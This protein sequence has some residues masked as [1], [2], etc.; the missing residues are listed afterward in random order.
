MPKPAAVTRRHVLTTAIAAPLLARAAAPP[1]M[2]AWMR[3]NNPLERYMADFKRT[4]DAWEEG[5]VRGIAIGRMYFMQPGGANLPVFPA[6]P[7]VYRA[8]GVDP[9][10]DTP[11]DTA[12]EKQLRAMLDDMARRSWEIL[13]FSNPRMGGSLPLKE[14]PYQTAGFAAGVQDAVNAFPQ[15]AGVIVDGAGEHHYELAFHHGGE[16]F[17]LRRWERLRYEV[18][19]MD[20]A[21]MERGIRR[22]RNRFHNLTPGMVRYHSPAGLLAGMALFDLDEDSLYWLRMRQESSM[23]YFAAVRRQMDRMSRK[24]KLGTIPRSAAFSIL[25]TQ[26]YER[27][28][29]YFDYVFPKHYFWHRGFDGMYGT[30]GRWAQKIQEWNPGL[31]EE[32]CFAVVKAWFGL[33]LPGVKSMADLEMGFPD[34]FFDRIVYGETR[35]ALE[36]VGDAGKVIAWVSSG[37]HPHDGDPMPARDLHRILAASRRAGLKRFLYQPDPDLGAP[38]WSVISGFCG[39]RWKEDPGG[40]WPPDT[41]RPERTNGG[42]KPG[43][44]R[45]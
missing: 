44:G 22:L 10:P 26:D 15:V 45:G 36:A 28:H 3:I 41:P 27:M 16:L 8:F 37:R 7:K 24:V 25:T 35:R 18:L 31:N 23:G 20:L 19:G 40:Y 2:A 17:E 33:E 30:V 13:F 42:R 14:D 39:K 9:P 43:D 32:D 1:R 5:G 6:D 38:E 29:P 21:R 4:F 11:R 34:E 12:K